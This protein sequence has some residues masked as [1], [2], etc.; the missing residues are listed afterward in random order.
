MTKILVINPNAS[1]IA[2]KHIADG[3]RHFAAAST[4][5]TYVNAEQGPEAIDTPLD[6]AIAALEV[7]RLIAKHREEYDA[8]VVA[9]GDDPGLDIGRQLTDKPVVGIAE[10][11]M[12]CALTLGAKFSVV[13]ALRCEIPKTEELVFRY[14]L[15]QRLASVLAVE[16]VDSEALTSGA[17]ISDPTSLLD[18]LHREV[19]RAVRDDMCDVVV[20]LGSVMCLL[21]QPLSELLGLPVVSG[22]TCALKLAESLVALGVRTSHKYKYLTPPKSDRLLGYPE[23]ERFYGSG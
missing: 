18:Q 12:L 20:L 9:A 21:V 14:G 10:A 16:G 23:F 7:A 4:D 22:T 11:G 13:T 1:P 6:A 19:S 2:T 5:V 8:F 15:A 17:L 3:S